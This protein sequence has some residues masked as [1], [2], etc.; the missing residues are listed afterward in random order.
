[1][2]T[3]NVPDFGDNLDIFMGKSHSLSTVG[4]FLRRG[5]SPLGERPYQGYR[6]YQ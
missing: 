4:T 6:D 3:P 1:M 5:A 2:I